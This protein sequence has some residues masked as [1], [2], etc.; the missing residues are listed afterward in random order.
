MLLEES[1]LDLS[2][3]LSRRAM[4]RISM[5]GAAIISLD[6]NNNNNTNNNKS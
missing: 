5:S 2:L 1:D 6:S 4:C 3:D